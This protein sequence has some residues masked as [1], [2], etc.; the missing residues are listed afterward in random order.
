MLLVNN[1]IYIFSGTTGGLPNPQMNV[2]IT[3]S[4]IAIPMIGAMN[5]MSPSQAR[6][7]LTSEAIG[8]MKGQRKEAWNSE[9]AVVTLIKEVCKQL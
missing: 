5:G 2:S 1:G 3:S 9:T 6:D 7:T 4:R 8:Q